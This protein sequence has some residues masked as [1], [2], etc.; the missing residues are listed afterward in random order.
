M[1]RTAFCSN[2][3]WRTGWHRTASPELESATRLVRLFISRL[4]EYFYSRVLLLNRFYIF[5]FTQNRL[6][7]VQVVRIRQGI[8]V[9]TIIIDSLICLLASLNLVNAERPRYA[10]PKHSLANQ[11]SICV[12]CGRL[13]ILLLLCISYFLLF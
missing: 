11:T 4:L 6:S 1:R 5:C 7:F 9:H 10:K 13:F 2:G 8:T 12:L 3:T